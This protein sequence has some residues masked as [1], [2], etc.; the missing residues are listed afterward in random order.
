V[1]DL[2]RLREEGL[3][4]QCGDGI[5]RD[6]GPLL[7][8]WIADYLEYNKLLQIRMD[9][10]TV[11][12]ISKSQLADNVIATDRNE[13]EAMD[14]VYTLRKAEK[15][16]VE[17]QRLWDHAKTQRGTGA[18]KNDSIWKNQL[19]EAKQMKKTLD[20]YFS[21]CQLKPLANVL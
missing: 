10:C 4:L 8:S 12:E 9:G 14:N 15:D 6:G 19:E 5:I 11:C 1:A 3:P 18:L 7:G 21:D 13:S 2:N 20:T 17:A 16:F